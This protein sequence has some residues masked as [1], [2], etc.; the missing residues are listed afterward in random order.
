MFTCL[1]N[2]V[3][4]GHGVARIKRIV[5]KNVGGVLTV[6]YELAFLNKDVT[7]LVPR[8]SALQVGLRQLSSTDNVDLVF[9][10]IGKPVVRARR[11]PGFLPVVGTSVIKVIS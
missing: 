6:F 3:Y 4:P 7:V 9:E 8:E 5:E 1:E 11:R 2:V 10:T